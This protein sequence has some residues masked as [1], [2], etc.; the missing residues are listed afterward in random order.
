MATEGKG[1]PAVRSYVAVWTRIGWLARL[2]SGRSAERCISCERVATWQQRVTGP[3][4]SEPE[5][6]SFCD[7]HAFPEGAIVAF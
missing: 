1:E 3:G 7:D 5:V 2:R 6:A 4:L